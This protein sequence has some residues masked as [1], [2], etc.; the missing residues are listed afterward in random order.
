[1]IDTRK[2]NGW[3][4][5]TRKVP[6]A[7]GPSGKKKEEAGDEKAPRGSAG[8][9]PGR[10]Y[11]RKHG[12]DVRVHSVDAASAIAIFVGVFRLEDLLQATLPEDFLLP[13]F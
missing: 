10:L 1:V 12:V 3:Q 5:P 6:L 11:P 7:S 2:G 8:S 9:K 4:R 13:E